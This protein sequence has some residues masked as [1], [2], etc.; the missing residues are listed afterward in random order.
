MGVTA[1]QMKKYA[2][3]RGYIDWWQF[4]KDAGPNAAREAIK[5]IELDDHA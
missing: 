1:K 5:Q 4:R 2:T 3:D